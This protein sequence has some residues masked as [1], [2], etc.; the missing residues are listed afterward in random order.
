MTG[1]PYDVREH[2]ERSLPPVEA[3]LVRAQAVRRDGS[4]ALNLC[5]LACGRFDGFW[6]T[7]LSPWDVAAGMLLVREAGGL[8]T[9]YDGGEFAARRPRDP[10]QQRP[11]ST[12]MEAIIARGAGG[13]GAEARVRRRA[14]RHLPRLDEPQLPRDRGLGDQ[15]AHADLEPV[16]PGRAASPPAPR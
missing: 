15:V 13:P 1:F 3:F 16:A 11:T 6:E 7:S 9:A 14:P 8:V 4:A 10:R 2:P 12:T 5:Y